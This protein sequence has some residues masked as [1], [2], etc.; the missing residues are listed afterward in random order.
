MFEES[1]ASVTVSLETQLMIE[2]KV[3]YMLGVKQKCMQISFAG[4]F[5]EKSAGVQQIISFF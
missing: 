5:W 1:F 3:I 2:F 4:H